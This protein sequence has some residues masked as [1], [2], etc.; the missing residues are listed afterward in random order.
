[1][2]LSFLSGTGSSSSA[3]CFDIRLDDDYVVFR[4]NE[5]EAASAQLRGK[6]VLC[7][8]EP[9]TIKHL[10]M[11][12][13]GVSKL[14][15]IPSSGS[16]KK[17]AKER[18]FFEKV[19]F[20]RDLAKGKTETLKADNYEYPFNIVLE[21][22]LPESVEGLPDSFVIYRFKAEIGRKYAKD[23]VIR[24]PLRII[25]TLNPSALELAHAMTV[26]NV[27]P[28][29]I[30][31]S[32]ST[33]SKA[34]IYGTSIHVEFR[35]VSLLKGLKIGT[36]TTQVV[37]TQEF[38]INPE[39][40]SSFLN[41]HRSTRVVAE[42][43][44]TVP[45]EPEI[46]DEE[47]EGYKFSRHLDLPKSLTKCMQDVNTK[48]IK[49]RHK[50]KFNVLLHNPDEHT[51]ELR[52]TLPVSLYISPSLAI[53]ENNELVDQSPLAACRAI[54]SDLTHR[55][56]PLYGEHQLDQMYSGLD[57][58]GYRTPGNFSNP[59][60]P[61][62]THSRNI[63]S[64][65]LAALDA[66]TGG[67]AE[68]AVN[69]RRPEDVSATALRHRLQNLGLLSSSLPAT[70]GLHSRGIS[71]E[72]SRH[73]SAV[74][75][76]SH[77]DY[78][79]NEEISGRPPS[80]NSPP[81]SRSVTPGQDRPSTG[82]V[83]DIS[84]RSSDEDY[85]HLPS[86]A[87]TPVPQFL[88]VEYLSRVPS[89]STAVRASA[90]TPYSGLDLPSYGDAMSRAPS[91]SPSPNGG[92]EIMETASTPLLMGE[93]AGDATALRGSSAFNARDLHLSRR[94]MPAGNV[95]GRTLG[96]IEDE[97]RRVRLMQARG[98]A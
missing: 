50:L 42:D 8:A 23:I 52:A 92:A 7:L 35:L 65:N 81:R 26:A 48:G 54:E 57:V 83:A 51:S 3:K 11:S 2:A 41:N 56:P 69:G 73:T 47:V 38:S 36:I 70:E 15:N 29:K 85:N 94:G 60:T 44:Y 39:A 16:S 21:G 22:S 61:F 87:Q 31:Y 32:I 95:H 79:S 91:L 89:Y 90:R 45:E 77:W 49:I 19:W 4:G 30:E 93:I 78:F 53:N 25:R 27:W 46:L 18:I 58:S 72:A 5:G 62:G 10:K 55:A 66:M 76:S 80:R 75:G 34:V 88:E 24:K 12:L 71:P 63:S 97:E 13:T 28:N 98:R 17:N 20:F 64:E 6:L 67:V 59:G 74:I 43:E 86:G 14:A 37:E 68:N 96:E 33:P 9:L 40:V 82:S 1:M 84:R